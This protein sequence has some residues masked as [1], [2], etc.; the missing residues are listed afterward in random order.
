MIQSHRRRSDARA[1][2]EDHDGRIV[3]L[4]PGV[5]RRPPTLGRTLIAPAV[6]LVGIGFALLTASFNMELL[7]VGDPWL[8]GLLLA[9]PYLTIVTG[10]IVALALRARRPETYARIGRALD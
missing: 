9:I 7:V 10:V 5:L 4:E 6:A 2:A 8:L 3:A 1:S